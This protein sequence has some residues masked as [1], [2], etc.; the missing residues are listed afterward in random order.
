LNLISL[1]SSSKGNCYLIND[2]SSVLMVECGLTWKR[3]QL[4]LHQAGY[5]LNQLDGVLITHEHGDHAKSW[6]QL[7]EAGIPVYASQGTIAALGAEGN[8][9]PL[10]PP[11]GHNV[12]EPS[13]I[14]GYD[15]IPFRTQHDAME[16]LGF[17]IRSRRDREKLAFATDTVSLGYQF[18]RLNLLAV[19]AN[20][21]NDILVYHSKIPEEVKRRIRHSHMEIKTL[22][23]WLSSLD[24]EGCREIY[25]MHLSDAS[26]DE[27]SFI[28][29]VQAVVPAHCRVTAFPKGG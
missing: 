24:L 1:G 28:R 20:Y 8:L 4:R 2:G 12:G 14:G 21:S 5:T 25:L 16:P 19:E 18:N 3:L 11:V 29:Q 23:K 7:C 22:C 27:E 13:S 26:G 10:A 6:Q 15:V 9:Y 17:L